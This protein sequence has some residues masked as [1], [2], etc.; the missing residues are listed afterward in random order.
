MFNL[1][2]RIN[3]HICWDNFSVVFSNPLPLVDCGRTKVSQRNGVSDC[4]RYACRAR[5]SWR[6][7][8]RRS[9]RIGPGFGQSM[10]LPGIRRY[11]DISA[12]QTIPKY[13]Y[14]NSRLQGP[15]VKYLYTGNYSTVL[16][17]H[18]CIQLLFL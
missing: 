8:A 3:D 2:V 14:L 15:L 12:N 11:A 5:S 4:E 7:Y 10:R 1:L 16:T 6:N 9:H 13:R 17:I 18:A